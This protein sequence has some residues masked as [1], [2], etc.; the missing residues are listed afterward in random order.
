[1]SGHRIEGCQGQ[2]IDVGTLHDPLK[3]LCDGCRASRQKPVDDGQ[4]VEVLDAAAEDAMARSHEQRHKGRR[5]E[6]LTFF[7]LGL[8]CGAM[9]GVFL[10]KVGAL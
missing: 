4:V 10:M 2:W 6:R 5:A 1:M 9:L 3:Q 8:A 7:A